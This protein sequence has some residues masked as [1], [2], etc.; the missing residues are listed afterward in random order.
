MNTLLSYILIGWIHSSSNGNAI[1][2]EFD[3]LASCEIAKEKFQQR[4]RMYEF[5]KQR[6]HWDSWVECVEK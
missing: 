4:H 5:D 2:I 6:S 1:S 3:N